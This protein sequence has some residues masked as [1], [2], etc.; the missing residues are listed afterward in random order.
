MCGA[1]LEASRRLRRGAFGFGLAVAAVA[2]IGAP[3]FARASKHTQRY[4]VTVL[5]SP[6]YASI[7]VDANSGATLRE[8]NADSL[9]HPASLTKIMTLY[10]LFERLDSGKLK[11]NSPLAISEEAAAQS[12]TK[13][14]LKPGQF[15]LVED[16]IKALVT[17]SAND[18]AVAIAEA[19]A[20][21]EEEFARQMTRKARALGMTR[22][23]YRNA[24]GLPDDNQVTTARDQARLGMLIQERFPRFYR[25][26][27]TVNFTYHGDSMRNHNHLLG[28][29]AGVDGIKTG[30]THASGYNLITS[31]HR[32]GRHLVAVV[33]GG[34]T[35]G[36][37]DAH[38]RD[39]IERYIAEASI[40]RP[41]AA[42]AQAQMPKSEA[43]P[44]NGEAAQARAEARIEPRTETKSDA[45]AVPAA[46]RL[47]PR[48]VIVPV[49]PSPS[50][51]AAAI[52]PSTTVGSSDPIPSRPVKTVPVTAAALPLPVPQL[53]AYAPAPELGTAVAL[54]ASPLRGPA[55]NRPAE[56]E[57]ATSGVTG[58]IE[59][60]SS[61]TRRPGWSVQVGAF[62]QEHEARQRLQLA[63]SKAAELLHGADPYTERTL[64]GD[65]TLYRARFSGLDRTKADA[66]CRILHR[67]DVACIAIKN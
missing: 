1:A 25:Y 6:R 2:L 18:I 64:K 26:F 40:K 11:L 3:A 27:S 43:R 47:P 50:E 34:N 35:A 46:P 20:G 49:V 28:R 37:R 24:S 67:S 21:S 8:T 17:K 48:I 52:V 19:L 63:R 60:P 39:L 41:E 66:V 58:N 61:E 23:V 59:A 29:V 54:E 53:N 12:P 44:Q 15:I 57:T 56:E 62:D 5:G 32:G 55:E 16:A 38:M 4:A 9:R 22:T 10:L 14:G 36:Q 31:V 30:Y 7:V 33:M 13:L 42:V 51:G 45:P 65:K